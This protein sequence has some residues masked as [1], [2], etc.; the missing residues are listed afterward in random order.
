MAHAFAAH[1]GQGYLD[2]ALLTDD[3]AVLH[4][5]VLAAKAFIVLDRTKNPGTEQPIALGLNVR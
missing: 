3:T 2:A 1:L 5:L 4:A